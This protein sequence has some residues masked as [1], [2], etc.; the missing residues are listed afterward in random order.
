MTGMLCGPDVLIMSTVIFLCAVM[1]DS[2]ILQHP[3]PKTNIFEFWSYDM[4]SITLAIAKN[5]LKCSLAVLCTLLSALVLNCL[6]IVLE[7]TTR[8]II[9]NLTHFNWPVYIARRGNK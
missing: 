4:V 2:S 7:S 3:V 6:C 8:I 9:N 5:I 1:S